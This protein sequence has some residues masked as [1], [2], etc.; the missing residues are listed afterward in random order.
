[1]PCA[2]AVD[3]ALG[4]AIALRCA[5]HVQ[6]AVWEAA[7]RTPEYGMQRGRLRISVPEEEEQVRVRLRLR[8]RLGS[9]SGSGL[10]LKFGLGNPN[11]KPKPNPSPKPKPKQQ[12][13][14]RVRLE[15]QLRRTPPPPRLPWE[16]ASLEARHAL[17]PYLPP[18]ATLRATPCNPICHALQPY[19]PRPATLDAVGVREPRGSAEELLP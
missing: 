9:G 5:V 13:D 1:V 8:L 17:Q 2:C 16:Y 19:V 12:L 6:A 7:A 15:G 11:P 3:E 14:A 10:G 18:L 4:L